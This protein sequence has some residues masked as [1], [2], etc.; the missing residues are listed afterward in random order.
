ML[1][2][3]LV[4]L[5]VRRSDKIYVTNPDEVHFALPSAGESVGVRWLGPRGSCVGPWQG[6]NEQDV[7]PHPFTQYAVFDI[8]CERAVK[9]GYGISCC[10]RKW[11]VTPLVNL[12]TVT[13]WH[14]A[15]KK[16]TSYTYIGICIGKSLAP[17]GLELC[18]GRAP[19][20]HR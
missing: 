9:R 20:L 8:L 14:R 18:T 5:S 4:T 17:W 10:L 3:I 15:G 7:G 19:T 2:L 13:L 11:Q 6:G 1:G 12:G 16:H